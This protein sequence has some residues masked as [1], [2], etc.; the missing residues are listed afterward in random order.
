MNAVYWI[1]DVLFCR[2]DEREGEHAGGGDAVVEA[3][4]PAV[5]VNVR[6]V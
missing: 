3:E 6:H 5:D 4:H 2:Y 1:A